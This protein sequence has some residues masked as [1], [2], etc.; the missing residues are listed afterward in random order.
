ML[1]AARATQQGQRVAGEGLTMRSVESP[2]KPQGGL[3]PAVDSPDT[4][5]F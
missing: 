1:S 4:R 5:T 2:R 3:P